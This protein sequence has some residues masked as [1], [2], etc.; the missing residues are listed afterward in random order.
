MMSDASKELKDQVAIVT[1]G[2]SGIGRAI[3]LAF[4]QAG[5]DVVVAA[6]TASDLD[7]TVA[8]IEQTGRRGLAVVTDVM[9]EDDLARD[10]LRH[11]DHCCEIE[12]FDRRRDHARRRELR[13]LLSQARERQSPWQRVP[14][15]K[16][17]RQPT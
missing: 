11:L 3:A 15:I 16:L 10:R 13:L 2:G 8:L 17:R 6:R 12:P 4:A 7:D 1:G 5:A 14:Q 9:V